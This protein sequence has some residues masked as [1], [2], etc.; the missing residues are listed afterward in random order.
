MHIIQEL[1]ILILKG[2]GQGAMRRRS[3]SIFMDDLGF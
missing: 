2:G 1:S 3:F